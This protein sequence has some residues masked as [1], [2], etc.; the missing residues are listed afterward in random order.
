[1]VQSLVECKY[2]GKNKDILLYLVEKVIMNDPTKGCIIKGCRSDW[3]GL[4]PNK[5]LFHAKAGCGIPIGNLTSQVFANYYLT[6]FDRFVK[7]VLKVRCYGRVY[8]E[9]LRSTN[10][11]LLAMVLGG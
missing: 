8:R 1:M 5:S 9:F 3:N 7:E 4:P 10:M 6:G 2:V 11:P